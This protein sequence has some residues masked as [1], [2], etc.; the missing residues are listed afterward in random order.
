MKTKTTAYPNLWDAAKAEFR[1]K[2]IALNTCIKG[3]DV[4]QFT[5]N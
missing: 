1:R 5:S 4:L 3:K 2:F